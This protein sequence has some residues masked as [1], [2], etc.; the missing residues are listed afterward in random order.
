MPAPFFT[1]L[2]SLVFI[3]LMQFLMKHMKDLIGKGLETRVIAEIVIYNLG[4]ILVLAVPMSVL[5]ATLVVFGKLSESG[6]Y[7]VMKAAGVSLPQIAW[8]VCVASVIVAGSMMYFNNQVLP[9][10]NYRAKSLWYDIRQ[11]KPAFALE[12]GMF[13]DGV[14][15]YS[16]R[17]ARIDQLENKLYDI[18]VFDYSEEQTGRVTLSAREGLLVSDPNGFHIDLILIDGA[19][20]RYV[21]GDDQR[22]ERLV[23][24]RYK[25]PLDLADI[26]FARSDLSSTSR[27]D[28]TTQT[29]V[30]M[31]LV[32]SL[33]AQTGRRKAEITAILAGSSSVDTSAAMS[34]RLDTARLAILEAA[35]VR[36]RDDRNRVQELSS[37]VRWATRRANRFKVEIHKKFSIAFACIV[38]VVIGIPLGLNV[39]RGGLGV[40]SALSIAI[41]TTYWVSLVQGEKLSDRGFL[42]PWIGMW[43]ANILVGT[44]AVIL[45]LVVTKDL[46]RRKLRRS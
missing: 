28:R 29:T 8:P 33:E 19:M 6:Y 39:R 34:T 46:K 17:A 22:Y 21:E 37:S 3:L 24:A 42:E 7:R 9:E 41:F 32:D 13:Y 35:T 10:S 38:F 16:I 15:G 44:A 43:I 27:S 4:Y 30:M 5:V 18:T 26:A 11:K 14:A 23:F 12:E 45:F 25:I 36:V 31:A 1:A 20:H 40:V 2:G